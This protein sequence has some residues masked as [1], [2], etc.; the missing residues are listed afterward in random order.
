MADE[1]LE[2]AINDADSEQVLC[3]TAQGTILRTTD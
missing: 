1:A 3:A 2:F